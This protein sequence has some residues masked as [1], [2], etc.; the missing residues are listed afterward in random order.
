M[1]DAAFLAAL[2]LLSTFVG[3]VL[4]IYLLARIR[5]MMGKTYKDGHHGCL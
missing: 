1:S 4:A 3:L 2:V 5:A